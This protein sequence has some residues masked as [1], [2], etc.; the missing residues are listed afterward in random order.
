MFCQ[1]VNNRGAE[2]FQVSVSTWSRSADQSFSEAF[3]WSWFQG[4]MSGFNKNSQQIVA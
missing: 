3:A 4:P 1:H 2:S